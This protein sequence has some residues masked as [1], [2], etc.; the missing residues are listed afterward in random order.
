MFVEF[1][2]PMQELLAKSRRL[3]PV[4]VARLLQALEKETNT[5]VS[6][7]KN[8]ISYQ[9]ENIHLTERETDVLQAIVAGLSNKEIEASLVISNNTVR[10]HIKNLYSKLGVESRTQAI[11]RA[12]ELNLLTP[13]Q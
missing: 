5:A 11:V 10:T 2:A 1:G 13:P 8:T 7:P 3:N 9:Q 6:T 4:Y 12:Q